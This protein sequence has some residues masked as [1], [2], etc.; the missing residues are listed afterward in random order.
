MGIS[1]DYL[2]TLGRSLTS[3]SSIC[4]WD[5]ITIGHLPCGS[6]VKI[7]ESTNV[8]NIQAASGKTKLCQCSVVLLISTSL[9]P[10][11]SPL[12]AFSPNPVLSSPAPSLQKCQEN[13]EHLQ[14][15][16]P[17]QATA[18][19]FISFEAQGIPVKS[20]G[21]YCGSERLCVLPEAT[22]QEWQAGM[23]TL[24]CL[25]AYCTAGALMP[26]L[27]HPF[28]LQGTSTS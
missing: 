19:Y 17:Q 5:R 20:A 14:S 24:L 2:V 25:L 21:F 18:S 15:L 27:P 10:D 9:F 22:Q 11:F 28:A 7:R 1:T 23:G 13:Q 26:H 12:L 8:E 4:K 3:L 6:D 16:T